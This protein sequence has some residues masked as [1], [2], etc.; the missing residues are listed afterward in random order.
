LQGL[1]HRL[2]LPV[3][4]GSVPRDESTLRHGLGDAPANASAKATKIKATKSRTIHNNWHGLDPQILTTHITNDSLGSDQRDRGTHLPRLGFNRTSA[5]VTAETGRA[6]H[7]TLR[8][9]GEFQMQLTLAAYLLLDSND[10][11]NDE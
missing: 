9:P 11:W 4:G 7:T 10:E 6:G 1:K 8:R 5:S 3:I 2:A